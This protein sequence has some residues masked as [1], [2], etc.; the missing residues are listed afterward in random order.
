MK[1]G[2]ITRFLIGT[3]LGLA[4]AGLVAFNALLVWVATGPRSLDKVT[5]YIER[6]LTGESEVRAK[7]GETLLIWDGWQQPIDI[8]LRDVSLLTK[9]GRVFSSFPEISLGLDVL[10][11]P[12]GQVLPTSLSVQ[13]PIIS[14][15]QNADKSLGFGDQ[16]ADGKEPINSSGDTLAAL[17]ESLISPHSKSSLRKLRTIE[18]ID[19]D[20]SIGNEASG[21]IITAPASTLIVRKDSNDQINAVVH[22]TFHYGD[23]KSPVNGTLAYNKKHKRL[24]GKL[25]VAK[26]QVASL[27]RLLT[28]DPILLGMQF[29]VSG[30]IGFAFADNG[31]LDALSFVLDGG[32]GKIVH[33]RLDGGLA[34]GHFKLIGRAVKQLTDITIE[35]AQADFSGSAFSGALHIVRAE[36]EPAVSGELTILDVPADQVRRFWPLGLAPLTREWVTTNIRDG[37]IT[38]ATAKLNIKAGDLALPLLPKEAVDASIDLKDAKIRYLSDHPEVRGVNALIKVDGLA[39]D[40]AVSHALAFSDSKLSDGRVLIA[41]LNPDNPLIELSMKANAPASDIVTLLG[42]P[43]LEHAEH[44]NLDAKKVSGR[45]S[46]QAVLGFYFFAKDEQGNDMPLTYDIQGK[47][48]KVSAPAFLGRFDIAEATGD[49]AINE[50]LIEFT[51]TANVNGSAI[52]TGNVRYSFSPE[53]SV[54]TVIKASG[55]LS[56]AILARFGVVLPISISGTPNVQFDAGLSTRKDAASIE[57]FSVSGDGIEVAGNALLTADGKDVALLRLDK[58]NYQ[59][60]KL[61]SLEYGTMDGGYRI[62]IK[63][64]SLDASHML[65]K[66][67]DGFSFEKFP[68]LDAE[69]ALGTLIGAEGKE[70]KQLKAMAICTA[71][72]CQDVA[73]TALVDDKKVDL[74]I[75]REGK[76]RKLTA[77]TENAGGVLKALG[78]IGS[79]EG[80][81]LTLDGRFHDQEQGSKLQGTLWIQDYTLV[82]APVLAKMLSLASLT[83]FFDTL[84]G[85]GIGF[86][87]LKAP[88]VLEH[89]VITLRDAKTYGSAM[90]LSASGTITFPA[91]DLALDGTIVPSYTLN[92]VVGKVPLIGDILTGGEGQGVFAARYTMK[93]DSDNPDVSVNPLSIL[94]PGFLRNMFDAF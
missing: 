94:T 72:R 12:F 13:R 47:A 86:K 93:G 50:K 22:T 46:G 29:P 24:E 74:T 88:Y 37:G 81:N 1:A 53:E 73:V 64:D 39:L 10:A 90:G 89:D 34:I 60:T 35:K 17:I 51:G 69:V 25:D 92:N 75:R 28:D 4:L 85:K 44:L 20:L 31:K 63:G 76:N 59:K 21:V 65:E 14:I 80:G 5:P 26:L 52:S 55:T 38:K 43:M 67:G 62:R 78:I 15:K 57:H 32:R 27:S 56:D 7:I 83:G 9:E 33:E 58:A 36:N 23:E 18:L 54:D 68:A 61:S 71:L 3:T 77:A 49:L 30:R 41:D 6:A 66:K 70:L 2:F 40:A 16:V 45:V 82:N 8:R 91:T 84:S 79:M 48:D 42:L 87:K 11:L 19:A